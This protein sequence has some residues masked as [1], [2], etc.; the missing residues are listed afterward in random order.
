MENKNSSKFTDSEFEELKNSQTERMSQVIQYFDMTLLI[1]HSSREYRASP[2]QKWRHWLLPNF[3]LHH[4]SC[5]HA[6]YWLYPVQL[7]LFGF[8]PR[9]IWVRIHR[10]Y[11][12]RLLQLD[13]GLRHRKPPSRLESQLHGHI[14]TGQ[15][16]RVDGSVLHYL[17]LAGSNRLN[18]PSGLF[19]GLLLLS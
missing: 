2:H 16:G 10:I 1:E 6:F 19:C 4:S 14:L 12:I 17:S 3:R 15:L 18:V 13:S 5:W 11:W 8:D 7:E 9:K